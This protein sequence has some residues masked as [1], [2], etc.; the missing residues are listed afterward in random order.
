MLIVTAELSSRIEDEERR[1]SSVSIGSHLLSR[2]AAGLS[3][4]GYHAPSL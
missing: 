1:Y 4:E 2:L 3:V